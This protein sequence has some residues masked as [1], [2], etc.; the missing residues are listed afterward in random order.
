MSE[1]VMPVLSRFY[2]IVIRMLWARS[3]AAR[4]HAFY[5]NSELVISI[6]PVG[7][8]EGEAPP[9]VREKVM[10]WAAEHQQ[11]LLSAWQRCENHRVPATIAPLP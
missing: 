8:I 11:E 7:I 3:L 5:E 2:G 10:A 9:W 4:F 6:W 1:I